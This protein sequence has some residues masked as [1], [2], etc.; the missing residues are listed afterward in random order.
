MPGELRFELNPELTEEL[1]DR[2]IQIW[3]DVGNA[4]G[5]VGVPTPTERSDVEPL[6]A[7]ALRRVGEGDDYLVTAFEDDE[8]VGF[9]FLDRGRGPLFR[10]WA[11][12]KRLQVRPSLQGRGIGGALLDAIDDYAV[13]LG[14]EQLH[15]TVRGG[16]G[17][18]TFYVRHGYEHVATIPGIIRVA[19]GDDRDE[20]YLIKKL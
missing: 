11:T 8:L 10:H 9:A 15:L 4:G 7:K 2:L 1:C 14:L 6:A 17:T 5:A 12:V 13:E 16:T 18:E 20:L 19:Q 3:T